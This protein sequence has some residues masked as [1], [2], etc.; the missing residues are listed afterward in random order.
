VNTK[1]SV[2]FII[3]IALSAFGLLQLL[4]R[5]WEAPL[6]DIAAGIV[7]SAFYGL[8]MLGYLLR[9]FLVFVGLLAFY[10]M[11][12]KRYDRQLGV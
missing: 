9:F 11:F 4:P 2:L 8:I 6:Q 7:I 3:V 12:Q 1:K 10:R 5:V